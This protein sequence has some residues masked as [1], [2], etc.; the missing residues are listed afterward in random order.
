VLHRFAFAVVSE[1]YQLKAGDSGLRVA[2]S[3]A[4]RRWQMLEGPPKRRGEVPMR[5]FHLRVGLSVAFTRVDIH[6]GLA[7]VVLTSMLRIRT[8][9]SSGDPIRRFMQKAGYGLLRILLLGR[10][11]NKGRRIGF[12]DVWGGFEGDR[13]HRWA[14]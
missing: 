12:G 14:R 2:G 1:W 8:K 7:H 4:T 5:D 13:E 3:F 6:P 9:G 11:V 10:T